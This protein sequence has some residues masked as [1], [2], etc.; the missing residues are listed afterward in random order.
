MSVSPTIPADYKT[1]K[2]ACRKGL[3]TES[4]QYWWPLLTQIQ[5]DTVVT[6]YPDIDA[7]STRLTNL[8]CEYFGGGTQEV[9]FEWKT[10]VLMK[11]LTKRKGIEFPELLHRLV[12]IVAECIPQIEVCFLICADIV[13]KPER[14]SN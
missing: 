9:S 3:S 10:E 4:R 8:V 2:N 12:R 14:L 13:N 6:E 5:R 7:T 1:L 11:A